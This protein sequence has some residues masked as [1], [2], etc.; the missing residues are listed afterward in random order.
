MANNFSTLKLENEL[1]KFTLIRVNPAK[2]ITSDLALD[3]GTTY[4]MTFPFN[5]VNRVTVDGVEY[6]KVSGAPSSSQFSFNETTKELIIN[7]GASLT[8]QVVIG[9]YYLFFTSGRNRVI[10]ETPDD[11]SSSLRDWEPNVSSEPNFQTSIEN[12]IDGVVSIASSS[13]TVASDEF[14]IHAHL[15]DDYSFYNKDISVWLC[16]DDLENIAKVFEGKVTDVSVLDEK[17]TFNFKDVFS[18]LKQTATMGDSDIYFTSESFPS[19]DPSSN[20]PPIPFIFGSVSQ[21]QTFSNGTLLEGSFYEREIDFNSLLS[22]VNISYSEDVTTSNNRVWGCCRVSTDGFLDF[23][24]TISA[25]DNVP[26]GYTRLTVPDAGE[27]KI[28]DTFTVAAGPDV[29]VR[30]LNIDK[31]NNYLYVTKQASIVATDSI[32]GNNCPTIVIRDG[33]ADT[34]YYPLYERDYTATVTATDGGNKYLK[35]TFTNNFEAT[36]SMATLDPSNHRVF[37]RVKPDQTNGT[38]GKVMKTLLEKTGLTVNSASITQADTDLSANANFSI[39]LATEGQAGDYLTYVEK[40]LTSTFGFL[41]LNASFEVEYN[42]ISTPSGTDTLDGG[43]IVDGSFSTQVEYRD[44]SYKIV[45]SN[46]HYND[47]ELTRDSSNT[48]TISS[49]SGKARYLHEVEDTLTFEHVL[50]KFNDSITRILNYR[51]NRTAK[52]TLS[53]VSRNLDNNVGENLTI[54]RDGL[55]GNSSTKEVFILSLNKSTNKVDIIATDLLGV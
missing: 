32:E 41:V 11:N 51:S 37:F 47:E 27:F 2:Y 17:I 15:G 26:V 30:V 42:I 13:V 50:E 9:F 34:T 16:L 18:Q 44:I 36:L 14:S 3:S 54:Q 53:T 7:L 46:P 12:S 31:A 33:S 19:V 39:P 24:Q 52:Y 45:A 6:T 43:N 22:A 28:G 5:P 40:L 8:S 35:I 23:T 21:Y 25:V 1:E 4:S 10:Y 38:H 55:L 48:P 49:S 29:Q 20:N